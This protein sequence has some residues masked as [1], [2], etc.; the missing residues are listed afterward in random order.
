MNTSHINENNLG[1][2]L[3]KRNS[4]NQLGPGYFED[5]RNAEF[6]GNI[7]KKRKGYQQLGGYLPFRVQ[8]IEPNGT[9]K[10]CFN[11][12]SYIDLSRLR[13][14][15]LVVRGTAY[16]SGSGNLDFPSSTPSEQYYPAFEVT[17]RR[18]GTPDTGFIIKIPQAAHD[19]SSWIQHAGIYLST[20]QSNLTNEF[21][22]EDTLTINTTGLTTTQTLVDTDVVVNNTDSYI[23]ASLDAST[24]GPD[25]YYPNAGG[26]PS[27]ISTVAGTPIDFT[28]DVAD[29]TIELQSSNLIITVY[30]D[31]G[32]NSVERVIPDDIRIDGTDVTITLTNPSGNDY[33]YVATAVPDAQV[34]AG[35]VTAVAQTVVISNAS[36][37]TAFAVYTLSGTERELV[38]SDTANYDDTTK[39]LTLT[40]QT[41]TSLSY[42]IYY[43]ALQLRV[44]Q[45]CVDRNV[46]GDT[47]SS[48]SAV[49]LD[50]YGIDPLDVMVE[51]NRNHWLTHIDTY[52][53]A[54][55]NQLV[56]GVAGNEY[57][58]DST[59]LETLYPRAELVLDTSQYVAPFFLS[60]GQT[61]TSSPTGRG[62]TTSTD[63]FAGPEI[64]DIAYQSSTGYV[65]F[66]LSTPE[67]NIDD[68]NTTGDSAFTLNGSV[69][70][71]TLENDLLTVENAGY[72]IMNGDHLIQL[73]TLDP[74]NNQILVDCTV[75]G[76]T[77]TDFDETD[78]GGYAQV[79]TS[80]LTVKNSAI[81]ENTILP[82]NE[83]TVGGENYTVRGNKFTTDEKLLIKDVTSLAELSTGLF[84]LATVTSNVIP[85]RDTSTATVDEYVKGD[86]VKYT[87]FERWIRIDDVVQ[88]TSRTVTLSGNNVIFSTIGDALNFEA[89]QN[90]A[91]MSDGL[92]GGVVTVNSVVNETTL[93]VSKTYTATVGR[94][95]GQTFELDE[96]IR[97]A[98]TV[99]NSLSFTPTARWHSLQK[100]SV[101]SQLPQADQVTQ[102]PFNAFATTEQRLIK[103]TMVSDN[104]YLTNGEDALV[105]YDGVNLSRAGLFR[106]EGAT[107]VRKVLSTG[108]AI[109][110]TPATVN[111]SIALNSRV[112]STAAGEAGS[113]TVGQSVVL[114]EFATPTNRYETTVKSIDTVNDTITVELTSDSAAYDRI[115]DASILKYYFRLNLIDANNNIIGSAASGVDNNYTIQM[116]DSTTVGIKLAKPGTLPLFDYNRLEYEVYRTKQDGAVFFKVAT[117]SVDYTDGNNYVYFEDTVADES[118][119]EDDPVST[120]TFGAEIATAID[121]PLRARFITSANNRLILGNLKDSPR[122]EV[123]IFRPKTEL[124]AAD[125][126]DVRFELTNT[127]GTIEYTFT[128][129]AGQAVSRV[130][131]DGTLTGPA[132]LTAGNW[133][134]LYKTSET[135]GAPEYLGWHI[136]E[137]STK[138]ANYAGSKD[139]TGPDAPTD[140]FIIEGSATSI[141]IWAGNEFSD[142]NSAYQDITAQGGGT[143][144][145][146]QSKFI[147]ALNA[148]QYNLTGFNLAGEGRTDISEAGR[149]NIKALDNVSFTLKITSANLLSESTVYV[150]NIQI[151]SGDSVVSIEQAYNSRM[152]VSFPNFAEVF[153]RPRAVIAEDSQSVIDVN[154]AD[155]QEITGIIPFFGD[156]TSQDSR[157]QDIVIC[158]KENS[159]YAVN[160]S[161]RRVTKIDSRGVGCNAPN[162]IAAVPNGIIFASKSGVY[163]LNRSFD[164]IWVG[165]FIDRL[166]QENTNLDQLELATGH[167]Y[168]QQQQ[169]RLSVPVGNDAFNTEVY[170]YQYGDEAQGRSGSWTRFDNIPS[171]GWASDGSESYFGSTKGR[172]YTI[173]NTDTDSDFRDDGGGISMECLYRGLHFGAPGRRKVVRSIVSHFRVLKTDSGTTMN[174]G[175]DLTDEF[176]PTSSFKLQDSV[177]DGLSTI[178]SSKVK[179]IRQNLPSQRGVYFQLQ[180]I[181]QA[182]DT[183]VEL[184]SITFKVA[185]LDTQGI[186]QAAETTA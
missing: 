139:Y 20:S 54:G 68:V 64:T 135:D 130:Q 155:G 91:I 119:F 126:A 172:M 24:L 161:T 154:S 62:F 123:Q 89:G 11:L 152:L 163:R 71:G 114:F 65:R 15:P 125:L 28:F 165:R 38:L 72:A 145:T 143:Q 97:V 128:N 19:H 137:T 82:G 156:S 27:F 75:T 87:D 23:H 1:N 39:E 18:S 178:I 57:K 186:T 92:E 69:Y 2:G 115:T 110:H 177:E 109:P 180:Y 169:Y 171:T 157:K 50:V 181:N 58:L 77:N 8:S 30:E 185:G 79:Y 103:S 55:L 116:T 63:G 127:T 121:E 104:M 6:E 111:G 43:T 94:L 107:F 73:M 164:V 113:F 144:L 60:T 93:E 76:V 160:V 51:E 158:F 136:L 183:P 16:G 56:T 100:A 151:S 162:S 9:D 52:R 22:Y 37:F 138:L 141:P 105:K 83:I 122:A 102:Y 174:V 32:G 148:T 34:L 78:V 47:L 4:E 170:T 90:I 124:T 44:N 12:D 29:E 33:I 149:F 48:T 99:D 168:P 112:F 88:L 61:F 173:R 81:L 153:D 84:I 98:D 36:P 31:I 10:I 26:I 42:Q 95:V 7:V 17:I 96:S 66:T 108:G 70:E 146:I 133:V 86:M 46:L 175:V 159:I 5:V 131:P 21:V 134:Y 35:Q 41:G 120:S 147:N 184:T 40:F 3:D 176:K 80:P 118:L 101:P 49:E 14:S 179:S 129:T 59:T 25:H 150:N 182:I 13:S 142:D 106:W 45:F 166:W 140:V 67:L 132:G 85:V 53:S 117:I 167:V 74:T